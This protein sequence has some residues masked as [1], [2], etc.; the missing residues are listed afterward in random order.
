MSYIELIIGIVV[1]GYVS[2]AFVQL[3]MKVTVSAKGSGL[4]TLANT[5][6]TD[7][8]EEVKSLDYDD[9]VLDPNYPAWTTD[10]TKELAQGKSFTRKIR[11]SEL[12][13]DYLKSIEVSVNWT[14]NNQNKEITLKTNKANYD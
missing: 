7:R 1:L 3:L 4:K 11:I 14:E 10:S 13:A 9:S 6:A 12:T 2:L 5:W 8:M